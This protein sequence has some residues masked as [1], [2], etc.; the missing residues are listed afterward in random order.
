MISVESILYRTDQK[1]N[2][3]ST[4]DHQS[5]PVEDKILAANEAQNKLIKLKLGTNN[6]SGLGFD[7]S[8]KRYQ[9][10]EGLVVSYKELTLT[11]LKDKLNTFSADLGLLDPKLM[12]Y[13]ASYSLADKE[14]CTN[15]VIYNR[16]VKHSDL[17][18]LMNNKHYSPSFEYQETLA[19]L[20]EGKINIHS[21]GTFQPKKVYIEYIKYPREIDYGGYTKLDG[22]DSITQDSELPNYLEDE[23]IELI[24]LLL[25]GPTENVP[26]QASAK[27]RF[28][29]GE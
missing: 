29:L 1:L 25:A 28:N 21:D 26:A 18:V 3:L 16:L 22:S 12:I 19:T 9:D 2:K 13:G 4:N 7:A 17:L 27:E 23:L 11:S 5:I 14:K 6:Q 24:V 8:R 20:S 15:R 10:L